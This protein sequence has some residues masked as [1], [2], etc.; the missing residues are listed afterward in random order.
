MNRPSSCQNGHRSL[1]PLRL[2]L[3]AFLAWLALAGAWAAPINVGNFVWNDVNRNGRQD[4]GESGLANVTVQLWNAAKNTLFDSATTNANGN[5]T[6]VAP[7]P[8][9]YR[10]RVVLPSFFD[11]FSPKDAA[12]ATDLTDSDVNEAASELGFTDAY[13]LASN[14]IS[15]TSI[16]VGIIKDRMGSNNIGDRVFQAEPDGTQPPAGSGIAGVTVRLLS[17]DGQVL[18]TAVSEEEGFY[19]FQAAPGSYRLKFESPPGRMPSAFSNAGG[20]DAQDSDIDADGHTHVFTL[21]AGQVLRTLDAGFVTAI[22][23]GNFVWNDRNGDGIQTPGEPPLP[24]VMVQLW[25]GAKNRLISTGKTNANGNYTLTA[26]GPNDYRLRVVLPASNDS[27]T[28]KDS[29]TGTDLNDS[30]I[31]GS[32]AHFGFTDIYTFG[33]NLISIT[34]MDAG[35]R[36][37]FSNEPF[38][39]NS[40]ELI[41]ALQVR[42][43]FEAAPGPTYVFERSQDLKTWSQIGGTFTVTDYSG[44]REVGRF[45]IANGFYPYFRLKRLP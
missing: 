31:N 44:T 36:R 13:M 24:G 4:A 29:A 11:R 15:I 23:V 18:Q 3:P 6:L 8:G 14:V 9:N 25:N 27:F 34:S 12:S 19:A 32:G 39:V 1:K 16:D 37:H 28:M 26:P 22:N 30:D 21:A 38:R 2:I 17:A 43:S 20:D 5:Y 40:L 45:S 7:E 35:I 42:L 33:N 41:S 10:V